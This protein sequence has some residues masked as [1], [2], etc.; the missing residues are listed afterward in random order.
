MSNEE[1]AAI[2][3]DTIHDALEGATFP[4]CA[5]ELHRITAIE[6]VAKKLSIIITG[7][8]DPEK[9][10]TTQFAHVKTDINNFQVETRKEIVEL[11]EQ[12]KEKRTREWALVMVGIGMIATAI[13]GLILK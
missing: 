2:I 12:N 7:N 5:L 13:G 6:D 8:G 9:G 3:K 1:I 11:K 10:L 4:Q